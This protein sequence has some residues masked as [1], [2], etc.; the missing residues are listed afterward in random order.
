MGSLPVEVNIVALVKQV[1]ESEGWY[2]E[3]WVGEDSSER[4]LENRHD[5]S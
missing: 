1:V 5:E 2:E 4:S 3:N